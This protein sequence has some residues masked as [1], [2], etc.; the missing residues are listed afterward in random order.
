ML[1]AATLKTELLKIFDQANP[2][3][4]G[5]PGTV[6]DAASNWANAYNTYAMSATTINGGTVVTTNQA[7][8][9][10]I[11]SAQ[12]PDG[13][14]GTIVTAANAFDAAFCAYWTGGVF[15]PGGLPLVGVGGTGIFSIII[16]SIVVAVTTG[17]LSTN[18][19]LAFGTIQS[20]ADAAATAISNAFHAA[21]IAAVSVLISG[22][23]TTPPPAAPLPIINTGTLL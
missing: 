19:Q 9:T 3:F 5:F 17:V 21:T 13:N 7:G 18:L 6:A 8:F 2:G 4:L 14:T 22:L 10:A 16:S 1:S 11:L 23:D 20:D 12:L 15:T